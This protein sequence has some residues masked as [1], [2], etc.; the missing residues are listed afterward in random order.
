MQSKLSVHAEPER[1][2][3]EADAEPEPDLPTASWRNLT[4]FLQNCDRLSQPSGPPT[5]IGDLLGLGPALPSKSRDI[6][7]LLRGLDDLTI[8]AEACR[9]SDKCPARNLTCVASACPHGDCPRPTVPRIGACVVRRVA[10]QSWFLAHAC[11]DRHPLATSR[12]LLP[13]GILVVVPSL[14]SGSKGIPDSPD[15]WVD[16]VTKAEANK[17]GYAARH[18]YGVH[19]VYPPPDMDPNRHPVWTKLVGA[20]ALI[21]MYDWLW[22]VDSDALVM[23]ASIPL[24]HFIDDAYDMVVSTFF[25]LPL[26]LPS[27]EPSCLLVCLLTAC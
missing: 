21:H 8:V 16:A 23:N 18:G 13:A 24:T 12:L 22:V 2:H 27:V 10:P 6:S 3:R 26:M 4:D 5:T 9:N 17:R 11:Q 7:H 15:V 19:S 20:L 1:E 14:G 25:W